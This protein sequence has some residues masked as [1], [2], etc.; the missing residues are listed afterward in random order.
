MRKNKLFM[1]CL[2]SASLLVG[3]SVTP[4]YNL[5]NVCDASASVHEDAKGINVAYHTQ[6]EIRDFVK[7]SG[8]KLNDKL[9]FEEEPVT[10][11]PFSLGKLSKDTLDSSVAMINQIRYIAGLSYNVSISDEYCE[12]TQAAA[13]S[14]YLNNELSHFPDKPEGMSDE[15]YNLAGDGASQS[16]IAWAS[17]QNRSMNDTTINGWMA[18]YNQSNISRVGHR[19]WILNP[20][21]QMTGFGSVT[22]KNGTYSAMYSFDRGNISASEYGVAWPAQ[23]TPIEYFNEGYPWSISMGY[24]INESNIN[25][26]LTRKNDGRV[27]NF[28]DTSKDGAFYVNNGGY[29]Q[30]GCIIFRPSGLDKI[31]SGDSF[32]VEITG[33]NEAVSYEVNFFYLDEPEPTAT[34]TIEPAATPTIAPTATPTIEPTAI[35][36]IRPTVTPTVEPTARPTVKPTNKPILKPVKAPA[37]PSIKSI[38][39]KKKGSIT[40][41]FR[42]KVKNASGYQV[43]YSQKKNFKSSKSKYYKNT[44]ITI[45]KLSKGK[46]YYIKVRAYAMNGKKKVYGKWS[47]IKTITIKK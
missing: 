34:P 18:D 46:K 1:A 12:L 6:D 20:S 32:S 47:S 10:T 7:Q 14:N 17:W 16:N 37:V 5:G 27:W 23:N 29:G 44:N 4:V 40:I 31:S 36:T 42:K 19:R 33:L 25:V 41:T 22:G 26:K 9:T 43:V 45:N 35:P 39:N 24:D 2:L 8:A 11:E 21:M 28:S 30:E 3:N 15:M 13:L 38:S